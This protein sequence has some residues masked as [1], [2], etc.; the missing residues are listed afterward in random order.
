MHI[1][2]EV[3]EFEFIPRSIAMAL[4]TWIIISAVSILSRF[5]TG[6]GLI[7]RYIYESINKLCE[8]ILET[9]KYTP[10]FF[11]LFLYL[12]VSNLL[13]LVPPFSSPTATIENN[14]ACAVF[15]F[16]FYNFLGIKKLGVKYLRHFTGPN[17]LLAPLM[18]P[19][20]VISHIVRP[21]SLTMRLFGNI[22]A[23]EVV[24]GILGILFIN[25]IGLPG[26]LKTLSVAPLIIRPLVVVL[27][28]LVSIIQA[29]VFTIL[30]AIYLSAAIHED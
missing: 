1:I 4:I 15:V 28:F 16:I 2:P 11:M 27:G 22:L 26:I 18:I 13:G 17:I 14:L 29:G 21:F 6:P 30:S 23:K 12:L 10:V 9:E 5:F 24:L 3:L 20:E 25:F 8:E 19:I 7:I